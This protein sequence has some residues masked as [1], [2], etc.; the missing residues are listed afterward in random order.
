MKASRN[1][2]AEVISAVPQ[3]QME[4]RVH[5]IIPLMLSKWNARGPN[6]TNS[7][8]ICIYNHPLMCQFIEAFRL[9]TERLG[10]IVH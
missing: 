10:V 3:H 2:S 1:E 8:A 9:Q 7:Y 4:S 6:V 5:L